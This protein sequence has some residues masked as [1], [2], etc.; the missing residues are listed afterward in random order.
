MEPLNKSQ[1]IYKTAIES[2]QL[3][4]GLGPA[5]TGKTHVA[6]EMAVEALRN[7]DTK[8]IIIIRPLVEAGRDIGALPGEQQDKILPFFQPVIT[9]L[10]SCYGKNNTEYELEK[11]S[12]IQ[13]QPIEFVRGMTFDNAWVIVD[14]AEN[15]TPAQ[16]K[17]LLTRIGKWS[18]V[19]VNGDWTQSD[20]N[21]PNGLVDA[22]EKVKALRQ[23]AIFEFD[24]EDIVRSDL[25][26]QIVE[27]YDGP[28][29]RLT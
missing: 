24:N 22:V 1:S 14:E 17:A 25:T 10:E 9:I 12:K 4:F 28:Y 21:G 6:V 2:G 20:L 23:V 16:M 15:A 18:K 11:G 3:V 5:G 26:Q 19:I 8:H 29:R 13:L 7:K 27:A